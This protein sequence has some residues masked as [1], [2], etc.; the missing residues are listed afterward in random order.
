MIKMMNI[1]QFLVS[2]EVFKVVAEVH[3]SVN[4]QVHDLSTST[5]C[6]DSLL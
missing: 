5:C 2:L 6:Y 3:F 1:Q 4:D